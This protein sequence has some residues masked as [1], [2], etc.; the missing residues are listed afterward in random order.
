MSDEVLKQDLV[1]GLMVLAPDPADFGGLKN[2]GG[3]KVGHF[4]IPM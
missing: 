3:V 2:L 1:S 4:S